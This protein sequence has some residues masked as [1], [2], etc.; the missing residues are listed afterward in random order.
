MRRYRR[1]AI[2]GLTRRSRVT[3][4]DM[5]ETLWIPL[6]AVSDITAQETH[7]N[8]RPLAGLCANLLIFLSHYE[9]ARKSIPTDSLWY[10]RRYVH[11]DWYRTDDTTTSAAHETATGL[12]P[13]AVSDPRWLESVLLPIVRSCLELNLREH[14]YAVVYELLNRLDLYLQKLGREH[15]VAFAFKLIRDISSWCETHIFMMGDKIV[16]E[17]SLEHMQICSR[18]AGL[19]ISVL[20][21]YAQA[22]ESQGREAIL[23]RIRQISWIIREVHLCGRVRRACVEAT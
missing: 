22:T 19:P 3:H 16:E 11:P 8:G 2:V 1:V 9:T 23:Q 7:L 18:L 17:E 12:Q 10:E 13:K 20:L 21:T 5:R 6:I 14:R 4:I 15:Q